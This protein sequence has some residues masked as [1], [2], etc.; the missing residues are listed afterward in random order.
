MKIKHLAIKILAS[1]VILLVIISTRAS[2]LTP[3]Q[4]YMPIVYKGI[5]ITLTSTSTSTSTSTPTS[6]STSTATSTPTQT[7]TATRTSTPTATSTSTATPTKTPSISGNILIT[8]I[9]YDGDGDTE[10]NEYVEF[11]NVDTFAIQ[12]GGWT[13][14]D[15]ASHIYTFPTFVIQPNQTCRVYTNQI[16]PEWCSFS[17]GS[18]SAIW[19]NTGDCAYLRNSASVQIDDYCYP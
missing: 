10:P 4:N 17:Y 13:L 6:T 14:R 8:T 16:H 2:S 12:I 7:S 18:G 11:R 19:N 3:T 1:A 9:F 5:P 15:I